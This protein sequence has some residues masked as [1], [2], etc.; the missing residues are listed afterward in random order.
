MGV[1]CCFSAN[2][3]FK[4]LFNIPLLVPE[5]LLWSR[6]SKAASTISPVAF[7][8]PSK[9]GP[10]CQGL[11]D[12]NFQG[13]PGTKKNFHHKVQGSALPSGLVSL[14][15]SSDC[16]GEGVGEELKLKLDSAILGKN[17]LLAKI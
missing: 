3:I 4:T 7:V 6:R 8:T 13:I 2:D 9:D 11:P 15:F 10:T 12:Y 17:S 14:P 1:G 16:V 5:Q